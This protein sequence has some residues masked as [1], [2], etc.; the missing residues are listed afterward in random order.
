[1]RF[2]ILIL[3]FLTFGCNIEPSSDST[4][5][6][7][8]NSNNYQGCVGLEKLLD[9]NE[10]LQAGT[11]HYQVLNLGI[12][13]QCQKI[14]DGNKGNFKSEVNA[15]GGKLQSQSQEVEEVEEVENNGENIPEYPTR[16]KNS[17]YF[18]EDG[19]ATNF[20]TPDG[21]DCFFW[22]YGTG[23]GEDVCQNMEDWYLE[24]W[25]LEAFTGQIQFEYDEGSIDYQPIISSFEK[26]PVAI[27]VLNEFRKIYSSD[28]D[29]AY[30]WEYPE[31]EDIDY[32]VTVSGECGAF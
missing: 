12:D 27:C 29:A 10:I 28:Y 13:A 3:I 20:N 17:G 30:Y 22:D 14:I 2:I 4:E 25:L 23:Y 31:E 9:E 15:R 1:M 21:V 6:I 26:D 7:S 32:W 11:S 16:E 5:P 24:D 18:L 8:F 19:Q